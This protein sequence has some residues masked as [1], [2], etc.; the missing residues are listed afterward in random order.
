MGVMLKFLSE[1][2]GLKIILF[3]EKASLSP[4]VDYLIK[5]EN[6]RLLGVF[7]NDPF[8]KK[9]K[10][11]LTQDIKHFEKDFLII[12]SLE[13][14]SDTSEIVKVKEALKIDPKII[15]QKVVTES[16]KHVGKV[17]DAVLDTNSLKIA[18]IYVAPRLGIQNLARELII[19]SSRISAIKKR[20]IVITDD[21]EDTRIKAGLAA[22][23]IPKTT[24]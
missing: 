4:V 19:P 18:K 5:P 15:N 8:T 3:Q 22:K 1:L 13:A 7:T 16:G 20:V 23:V 24:S 12:S 9:Q 11:V 10:I 2:V 6:G 14:L 21:R 17:R